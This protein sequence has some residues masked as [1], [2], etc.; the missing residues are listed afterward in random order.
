[1]GRWVV[2]SWVEPTVTETPFY[3]YYCKVRGGDLT[4]YFYG[5]PGAC[6]TL[7]S[8]IVPEFRLCLPLKGAAN[9]DIVGCNTGVNL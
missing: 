5:A 4:D 3:D 1:M 7:D 8:I 9:I 6:C 2:T